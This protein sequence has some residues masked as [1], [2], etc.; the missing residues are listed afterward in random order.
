[1]SIDSFCFSSLVPLFSLIPHHRVFGQHTNTGHSQYHDGKFSHW[2]SYSAEY[3]TWWTPSTRQYH[4]PEQ[5]PYHPTPRLSLVAWS[6]PTSCHTNLSYLSPMLRR[7]KTRNIG[8]SLSWL[9]IIFFCHPCTVRSLS[10]KRVECHFTVALF[11]SIFV[12]NQL[13]QLIMPRFAYQMWF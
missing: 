9:R 4:L 12:L 2:Y 13:I 11:I 3:L 5:N 1:M 8:D 10:R 6:W 7:K